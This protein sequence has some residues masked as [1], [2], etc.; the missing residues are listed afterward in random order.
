MKN[1]LI[2]NYLMLFWIALI[3]FILL[4][5]N[6]KNHCTFSLLTMEFGVIQEAGETVLIVN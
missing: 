5:E 3:I 2:L 1:Q 4:K 6:E